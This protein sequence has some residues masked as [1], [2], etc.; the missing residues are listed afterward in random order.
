MKAIKEGMILKPKEN[1]ELE[2][3]ERVYGFANS[4]NIYYLIRVLKG[5][6]ESIKKDEEFTMT[7]KE[8]EKM[9]NVK[10]R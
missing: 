9:I 3:L 2:V 4:K 10:D 7:E 5:E 8:I 1:V 6:F